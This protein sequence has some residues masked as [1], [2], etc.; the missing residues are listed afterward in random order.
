[1]FYIN[2]FSLLSIMIRYRDYLPLCITTTINT[3]NIITTIVIICFMILTASIIPILCWICFQ[4]FYYH[5]EGHY[6][7]NCDILTEKLKNNDSS[8]NG[9]CEYT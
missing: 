9:Y 1:M 5:N 4:L 8:D 7:C 3:I 6:F 2:Y